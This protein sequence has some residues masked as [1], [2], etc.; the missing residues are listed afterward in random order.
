[1]PTLR[2][3]QY[4]RAFAALSVVLFHSL[5]WARIDFD[6]GAAGV[7]V[8]FVISGYVMWRSTEGQSLTP[9]E[10][11][12]RRVIR[13]VPLYWTATLALAVSAAAWPARFPEIDPQPGHVLQS[14]AFLQHRNPQGLPFPVLAPGWTLNYEAAFYCLFAASLLLPHS[15]R[16]TGLSFGLLAVGLY[17]FFHPPAYEMLANPLMLEFLAG[18]LLGRAA[19]MGFRPGRELSWALLAAAL[20]WYGLLMATRAEWDLW[21]PLFWGFP[22]LLLVAGL[23]SLEDTRALPEIRPLRALGDASYSLYLLHPLII[24]AVAVTLGTWR[25]WLFL[26]LALGLSCGLAWLS[27]RGFER[28]LTHWLKGPLPDP[29]SPDQSGR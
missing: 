10:F 16:L 8:F 12:R 9:L 17:G 6:I 23:T 21:R 1:M 28:P 15:Q 14:L 7:D 20:F 26:P 2:S 5:Q 19:S 4:L 25:L 13:V 11:M 18:V 24:G 22:A 27:W 3:I 29:A